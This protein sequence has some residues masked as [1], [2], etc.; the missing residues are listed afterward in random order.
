VASATITTRSKS[1]F[2][3][4]SVAGAARHLVPLLALRSRARHAA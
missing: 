3:V 4:A 2:M 1:F